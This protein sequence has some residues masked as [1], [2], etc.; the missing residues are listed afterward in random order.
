MLTGLLRMLLLIS[1]KKKK[2]IASLIRTLQVGSGVGS[3]TDKY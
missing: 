2:P 1:L 3:N